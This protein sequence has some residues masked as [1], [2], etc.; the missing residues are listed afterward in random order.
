MMHLGQIFDGRVIGRSSPASSTKLPLHPDQGP[1][2]ALGGIHDCNA[3]L[4]GFLAMIRQDAAH[5]AGRHLLCS[6]IIQRPLGRQATDLAAQG[7]DFGQ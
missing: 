2:Y 5:F 7:Y 3:L 1:I 6:N 4:Q